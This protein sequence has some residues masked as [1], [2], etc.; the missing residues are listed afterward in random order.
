[1]FV[2][3]CRNLEVVVI[4]S[5]FKYLEGHFHVLFKLPDSHIQKWVISYRFLCQ[6]WCDIN[7]AESRFETHLCLFMDLGIQNVI[8]ANQVSF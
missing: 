7:G 2:Y 6:K 1:M 8:Y 3:G 4:Y 5:G